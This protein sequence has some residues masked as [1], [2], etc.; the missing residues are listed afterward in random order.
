MTT[1][2][3]ESGGCLCGNLRYTFAREAALSAHHCHCSDCQ[4]VTGSGKAT[5]IFVPTPALE[6][7]D[8]YRT[9]T[10]TGSGGSHVTR[11]FCPECGSQVLSYVEEMPDL[12]FIKAGTLDDSSWVT[13][14]S[15]Y[16]ESSAQ[17][18]SPVDASIPSFTG[19]PTA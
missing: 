1:G 13:I 8:A 12:R 16:W 6:I 4:R 18:W 7:N 9:Y 3:R 10:V 11:G 15:S 14:T 17:P 5:I 19:N 2:K